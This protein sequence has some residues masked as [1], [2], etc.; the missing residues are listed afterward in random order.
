MGIQEPVRQEEEDLRRTAA[1][2]H[3]ET[4]EIHVAGGRPDL[5]VTSFTRAVD[6]LVR[7]PSGYDRG[8][9]ALQVPLTPSATATQADAKVASGA[10]IRYVSPMGAPARKPAPEDHELDPLEHGDEW[11]AEIDRRIQDVR[12]GRVKMI[13]IEE[14]EAELRAKHGW[15]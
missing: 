5:A 6:L 4:A 14:V 7:N 11:E 3:A 15:T 2:S 8:E 9:M 1:T 10:P 12:S 13:P